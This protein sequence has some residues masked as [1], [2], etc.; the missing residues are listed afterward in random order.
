MLPTRNVP[1]IRVAPS[2]AIPPRTFEVRM[3]AP[4]SASTIAGS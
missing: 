1:K 3:P 2:L 4:P